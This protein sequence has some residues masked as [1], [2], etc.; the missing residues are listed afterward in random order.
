MRNKYLLVWFV[1]GS[2]LK[3]VQGQ[4]IQHT[5]FLCRPTDRSISIHSLFV[6]TVEWRY[7]C[8]LDSLNWQWTGDWTLA[9]PDQK[10]ILTI[11][12]LIADTSY[13][14]HIQYRKPG[15]GVII[16]RAAHAFHTARKA[17]SSFTFT[18]QADPHLDVQSDT[19]VYHR[20]LLNQLEDKPDFMIDLGDYLM[21]DKCKN[22]SGVLTRD[23]IVQR[24][25][26]FRNSYEWI[27]HS[28]PIFNVMGNHEG[29]SGW[30]L[31]GTANNVAVWNALE[32][33]RFFS[34]PEPSGFYSGDTTSPAFTGP[35]QSY[36]AFT[37]GDALFI[38]IDPYWNTTTK[39]D[40]L[41]GWRWSLGKIQYDWLKNVLEKSTSTYTFLFSHQIVGGDASGRGGV[42][43]ANLYEWGGQNLDGT[44][45]FAANRPGWYKPIKDLLQEHRVTIFFHGHDHFFGKQQKECLIYQETPQPSHPNFT[46][47][48]YASDYGYKEGQILPNSG[49]I[50]V[51]VSP[52]GIKT[53]YVRVYK[54]IDETPNRHNKDVSAFYYVGKNNCYDSLHSSIPMIR[55]EAYADE[56]SYPNPSTGQVRIRFSLAQA[57][58][59]SIKIY[60]MQG[61]CVDDIMQH[62]PFQP[63]HYF[64]DWNGTDMHGN[65][66]PNGTY[67]CIITDQSGSSKLIRIQII[68]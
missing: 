56:L 54:P 57:Q 4:Q 58:Q 64:I 6:D 3:S 34:N 43:F 35:R 22:K 49:H 18:V 51:R 38:V 7:Q 25:R 39:P 55:N 9:Y 33:K 26:I 20:C 21:S 59:L 1:L 63:G 28:I 53:E 8:G 27:S 37:W 60:S 32:R 12:S 10:A 68:H 16:T 48:T 15:T 36:Y 61:V 11:S 44:N 31:N 2:I 42:E 45:G 29:E 14:Y 62:V 67:T 17:G 47:V 30:N 19:A 66:L 50:R 23:T 46:S 40:S 13:F 5:E 41:N 65:A 24:C 52:E